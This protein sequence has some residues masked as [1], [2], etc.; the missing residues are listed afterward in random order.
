MYL[1]NGK[2]GNE[3]KVR[4][5][6]LPTNMEKRLKALGMQDSDSSMCFV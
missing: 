2:A 1:C 3:Y 5:I 4:D 6:D